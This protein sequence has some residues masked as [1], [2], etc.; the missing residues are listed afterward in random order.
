[1]IDDTVSRVSQL[2]VLAHSVASASDEFASPTVTV[3]AS[4]RVPL[5]D[6]LG[7]EKLIRSVV[8]TWRTRPDPGLAC[9][10][11]RRGVGGRRG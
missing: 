9:K 1:M 5:R 11:G 7:N 2:S 4:S 6:C 3:Q 10:H 8:S